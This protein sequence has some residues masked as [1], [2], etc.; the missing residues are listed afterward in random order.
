MT[1]GDA[2]ILD[3]GVHAMNFGTHNFSSSTL[4][5]TAS[6][7]QHV[8]A[9]FNFSS[10]SL[11]SALV[12]PAVISQSNSDSPATRSNAE[13]E[14]DDAGSE[15]WDFGMN[16]DNDDPVEIFSDSTNVIEQQDMTP[17]EDRRFAHQEGHIRQIS[18][19]EKESEAEESDRRSSSEIHE[20]PTANSTST[21]AET[22]SA[23]STLTFV[24]THYPSDRTRRRPSKR[25]RTNAQFTVQV[26][27]EMGRET[28]QAPKLSSTLPVASE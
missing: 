22:H 17:V 15:N 20:N 10:S 27:G 18:D 24:N 28:Q 4:V 2:Q 13:Q 23:H 21:A 26:D 3:H 25:Q 19:M 14:H 16:L 12:E 8:G 11:S 9:S 1:P 5:H 7:N 6:P